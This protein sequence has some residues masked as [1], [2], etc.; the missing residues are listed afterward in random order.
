MNFQDYRQGIASTDRIDFKVPGNRNIPVFGVVGE[1]GSI[2]AELKKITRDGEMYTQGEQS[3]VE[4]FG[5]L[6]WYLLSV[7]RQMKVEIELP[8][9]IDKRLSA[10]SR[11]KDA[12]SHVYRLIE[13]CGRLAA[14]FAN[15]NA[16]PTSAKKRI[17]KTAIEQSLASAI[18]CIAREGLHLSDVL[19]ENFSKAQ[20]SFGRE[21]SVGP[22]EWYD[23]GCPR[24]EQ[25][26]RKANIHFIERD[27]GRGKKEV[28]IRVNEMNIGDRLTDN[29]STDDGY[30]FH[31]AFHLAYAAVL[32]WSPVTRV[33]FR[34]KRKSLPKIDEV[35][36]GA[37]AAIIEEAVT[38][39]IFDYATDHSMLK[40]AKRIDQSLLKLIKRMVRGLEVNTRS[41]QE[42]EQAILVGFDAFRK[43]KQN[44]GGWL[45]LDAE[46]RQLTYSKRGPVEGA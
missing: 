31:D 17:V 25:L 35:Q 32:G 43:L 11:A 44:A 2:T 27:R 4:E 46:V 28:V 5:D 24:Y 8:A 23:K 1:L 37:R 38:Q 16:K 13:N 19:Q 12:D 22:A 7:A 10:A 21:G 36:D 14:A 26:P 40:G 39:T 41:V 30:R 45:I 34:C 18:D 3:L 20:G 9:N 6:I 29:A 33:T 15:H 42:W